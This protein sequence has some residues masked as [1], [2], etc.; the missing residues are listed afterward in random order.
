MHATNPGILVLD[1][2]QE[3]LSWAD[4][5]FTAKVFEAEMGCEGAQP[6]RARLAADLVRLG[7]C[8][9]MMMR[10]CAHQVAAQ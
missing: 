4:L 7:L 5:R 2:V 3:L 9:C 1:L 6:H 8:C 10:Y